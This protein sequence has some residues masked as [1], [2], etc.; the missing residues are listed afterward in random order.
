[1]KRNVDYCIFVPD[2]NIIAGMY[3]ISEEGER[4]IFARSASRACHRFAR[5]QVSAK[6]VRSLQ[7][8]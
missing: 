2:E 1:M 7:G 8:T 5:L 6:I 4:T 3:M